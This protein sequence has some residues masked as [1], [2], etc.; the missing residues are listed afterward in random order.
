MHPPFYY[1]F[2]RRST[3][4]PAP[5]AVRVCVK[6]TLSSRRNWYAARSVNRSQISPCEPRRTGPFCPKDLSLSLVEMCVRGNDTSFSIPAAVSMEIGRRGSSLAALTFFAGTELN[7]HCAR[8][9]IFPPSER[10][11]YRRSAAPAASLP[12][13]VRF[14]A[15]S[16]SNSLTPTPSL[17]SFLP[18]KTLIF[19]PS[20]FPLIRSR[21]VGNHENRDVI[22][23]LPLLIGCRLPTADTV[24][25]R[26]LA[27]SL[28]DECGSELRG[29]RRGDGG[30]DGLDT[31]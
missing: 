16:I 23:C 5:R 28:L 15:S 31:R 10:G 6:R 1:N 25:C 27:I 12:Q 22:V 24:A 13:F 2:P 19:S 18:A 8:S 17:P 26:L 3:T 20:F 4:W 30:M 21:R 9:R 7:F 11:L 29:R 14:P